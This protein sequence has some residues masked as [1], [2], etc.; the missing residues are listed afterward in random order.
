MVTG[1]VASTTYTVTVFSGNRAGYETTGRESNR[2]S[3]SQFLVGFLGDSPK[4]AA[5]WYS[6]VVTGL[7]ASRTYTVK[8]FSGKRAGC[9][10][11]GG[12]YN[13]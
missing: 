2:Y 1:L 9:K 8:V 12:E 4:V 13:R 6:T 7:V 5:S 10:N 3:K 11:T